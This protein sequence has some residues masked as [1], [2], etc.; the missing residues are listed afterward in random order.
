MYTDE[1]IQFLAKAQI[2]FKR[3]Y[4]FKKF[5]HFLI[6]F[7]ITLLLSAASAFFVF[8]FILDVNKISGNGMEPVLPDGRYMVSNRLAYTM[9][10]PDRGDIIVAG[11]RV[12][13]IVGLPGDTVDYYGGHLLING[14]AVTEKYREEGTLTFPTATSGHVSVPE[15]TYYV[16]RDNRNCYDDSRTGIMLNKS[17][18]E[19]KVMFVF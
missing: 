12:Y 14:E 17:G 6:S 16:L 4:Q 18:I 3:E 9:L 13:R 19:S 10:S 11:G 7:T 5:I 8:N 2:G 1:Q 15:D